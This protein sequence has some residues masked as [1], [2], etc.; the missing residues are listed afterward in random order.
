M[1]TIQVL[2]TRIKHVY[3]IVGK[4]FQSR[5]PPAVNS[6][7]IIIAI[8]GPNDHA[9]RA[10]PTHDG[11]LL[12]DFY[13]FNHLMRG[14]AS[15]QHW[16]T[17]IDP[18]TLV[19]KY[20]RL[21]HGNPKTGRKVVLNRINLDALQNINVIQPEDLAERFLE[22][23]SEATRKTCG[24]DRQVLIMTFCHCQNMTHR[25]EINGKDDQIIAIDMNI[26]R[27]ALTRFNSSPV[28]TL[29][30]TSC[31]GGGWCFAISPTETTLTAG[32]EKT[33]TLSW[34]MSEAT[35]DHICGSRCAVGVTQ[36]LIRAE[37]GGFKESEM[38]LECQKIYKALEEVI[39]DILAEEVDIRYPKSPISF[40]SKEGEWEAESRQRIGYPLLGYRQRWDALVDANAA[41]QSLWRPRSIRFSQHL[42]LDPEQAYNRL[43]L[44]VGKYMNSFPGDDSAAKNH[45]VHGFSRDL[46]RDQPVRGI[47][48][49][50][51]SH[52]LRYRMQDIIERATMYKDALQ[53]DF[54]DCHEFSCEEFN[55]D[56][57]RDESLMS[58]HHEIWKDACLRNL[59]PTPREGEDHVYA[60]GSRCIAAALAKTGWGPEK[61][62]PALQTLVS[63][64]KEL[65][66]EENTCRRLRLREHAL[67]QLL[68]ELLQEQLL[69]Q[70]GIQ[71]HEKQRSK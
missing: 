63:V 13:L 28:V 11:W 41:T 56:H 64:S 24:T 45:F 53:L 50:H 54:P 68:L 69:E 36:A 32:H 40:V 21:L 4:T 30:T 47:D 17:S 48:L 57:Y 58:R 33:K 35:R 12:S 61:V 16:L 37:L 1:V 38:P 51:L 43:R 14:T 5:R 55:V 18:R 67:V 25:L 10:S 62:E 27:W 52:A 8:A 65:S 49:K 34:P 9:S 23:V 66:K 31:Y 59:F 7:S 70:I 60:K 42:K 44:L 15:E 22:H 3:P 39:H 46:L 2:A 71:M 6:D 26:M 29:M 20:G 19:E